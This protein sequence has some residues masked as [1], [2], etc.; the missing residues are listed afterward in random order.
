MNSS[1]DVLGV[2]V[3]PEGLAVIVRRGDRAARLDREV[4]DQKWVTIG[5][6]YSLATSRLGRTS[7]ISPTLSSAAQ[8]ARAGRRAAGAQ[9]RLLEQQRPRAERGVDAEHGWQ[10]LVPHT[11]SGRARVGGIAA[12]R[13]LRGHGLAVDFVSP[14]ASTEGSVG[15]HVRKAMVHIP[16]A[17]TPPDLED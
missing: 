13:G 4:G 16:G 12:G 3:A 5:N 10:H 11:D 6:G 15:D 2:R 14:V 7:P 17:V 9:L 8:H 1:D